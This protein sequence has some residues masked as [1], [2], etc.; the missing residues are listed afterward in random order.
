[1]QLI[2]ESLTLVAPAAA[3]TREPDD[4]P[5]P[6]QLAKA[7]LQ[8]IQWNAQGQ[9]EE[10][11]ADGSP[12]QAFD[13]QFNPATLKVNYTNQ[14]AGGDQPQGSSTQF[15]GKGT[16]KLTLELWFDTTVLETTGPG[17]DPHDVRAEVEDQR[18]DETLAG[19]GA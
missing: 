5:R 4:M 18:P 10:K 6:E 2:Y 9:A 14:K 1:M 13:V 11:R 3:R 8:E 17:G 15:V 7:K 19:A 12:S 16:T